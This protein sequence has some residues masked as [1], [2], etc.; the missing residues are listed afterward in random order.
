MATALEKRKLFQAILAGPGGEVSPAA[1]DVLSAMLIERAGF[2]VVT[3]ANGPLAQAHGFGDAGILT[4]T[5]QVTHATRLA[6]AVAVPVIADCEMPGTIPNVARATRE[7]ERSGVAAIGIED[8][9]VLG[10]SVDG[11]S[12]A[13]PTEVFSD[14]LKAAV[15]SR[16]DPT[17][18]IIARL[19][20]RRE[21]YERTVERGLAALEAGADALWIGHLG[22]EEMR[23]IVEDMPKPMV[24]VAPAPRVPGAYLALGYKVAVLPASVAKAACW[25]METYLRALR[26]SGRDEEFFD[27]HPDAREVADWFAAVGAEDVR[28]ALAGSRA[29]SVHENRVPNRRRNRE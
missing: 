4:I 24:G 27:S 5:E 18:S 13:V 3:I 22:S 2:R 8:E 1:H 9:A 17:M 29:T 21:P 10:Q 7:F 11:G 20:G 14:W 19:E 6:D 12:S 16:T 25:G 28:R 26:A 23:R 15:D